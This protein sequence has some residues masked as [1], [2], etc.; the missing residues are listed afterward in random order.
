VQDLG[1][2]KGDVVVVILPD[3]IRSYLSKFADDDWLAANDLLPATPTTSLPSSTSSPSLGLT[4]KHD[5][6]HGATVQS[7]RLKP[8]TSVLSDSPCAEAAE[9]MREKGFDQLPVLA[10][11]GGKLVGL[12]TLGNLLSYMS[13]GRVTGKSPVSQVMF[14]FSKIPEVITDPQDISLLGEPP[15]TEAAS[16][17]ANGNSQKTPKR[18]FVQITMDTPLTALSKFFEWNSAAI[19]TE[20]GGIDGKSLQKP[21]AVVTKV[22]LLSWMVKQRKD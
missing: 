22:D 3:S 4:S 20:K 6:Y 2:G 16:A 18:K 9:T 14:D 11:K 17:T 5:P 10:P 7:L 12:V 1:L 15:E 19:V 21:V 13:R 8:V